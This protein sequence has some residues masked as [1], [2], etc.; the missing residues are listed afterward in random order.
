VTLPASRSHY[1]AAD[2]F[3]TANGTVIDYT[4]LSNSQLINMVND[5]LVTTKTDKQHLAEV[6]ALVNGFSVKDNDQIFHPSTQLRPAVDPAQ[7][8]WHEETGTDPLSQA[9]DFPEKR[10]VQSS[11]KLYQ[12]GLDCLD[13]GYEVCI[14]YD[15]MA[16]R[17]CRSVDF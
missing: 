9:D 4:P 13:S 8:H 5:L 1:F 12:T 3:H 17:F 7:T 14:I 11:H 10:Y 2:T 6:F 15:A 16:T